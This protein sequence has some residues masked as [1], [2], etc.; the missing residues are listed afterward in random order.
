MTGPGSRRATQ[1]GR[2]GGQVGLRQGAATGLGAP[3]PAQTSGWPRRAGCV[4][5]CGLTQSWATR[6]LV[7][8]G[9]GGQLSEQANGGWK[10]QIHDLRDQ[11]R[12]IAGRSGNS[13]DLIHTRNLQQLQLSAPELQA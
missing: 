10:P 13:H 9:F 3:R 1:Q 12:V 7:S 8:T 4:D 11:T 5:R 6:H 2:E